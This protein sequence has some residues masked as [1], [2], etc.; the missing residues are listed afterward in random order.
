MSGSGSAKRGTDFF[1]PSYT[2]VRLLASYDV[3]ERLEISG[4]INN[5]FDK[6]YYPSSY[7]RVWIQPGVPRTAMV[8][9]SYVF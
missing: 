3:T 5:L 9:A 7:A 4:E 6:E 1:L 8:R 2:L